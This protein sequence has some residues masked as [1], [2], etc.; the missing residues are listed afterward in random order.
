MLTLPLPP[1]HSVS[2][3]HADSDVPVSL[4]EQ[5]QQQQQQQQLEAPSPG[6]DLEYTSHVDQTSGLLAAM[7]D[8]VRAPRCMR[9]ISI[10]TA[11]VL[12][13][14]GSSAAQRRNWSA[15]Q[16]CAVLASMCTLCRTSAHSLYACRLQVQLNHTVFANSLAR[17]PCCPIRR[18]SW[19]VLPRS[20]PAC[21]CA[22]ARH[23]GAALGGEHGSS[24]AVC[25]S[26]DADG[27]HEGRAGGA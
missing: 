13:C 17:P 6:A 12:I 24:P 10:R 11:I 21:P 4:L 20:H 25:P 19:T 2:R 7:P 26:V 8:R 15:A 3:C 5:Q 23:P 1:D 22:G 16:G 27:R 18:V 9:L 14:V